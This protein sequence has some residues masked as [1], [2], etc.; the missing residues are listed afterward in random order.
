MMLLRNLDN[1]FRILL[2][3]IWRKSMKRRRK[4]T[5]ITNS[6]YLIVSSRLCV[7]K[8]S[9]SSFSMLMTSSSISSSC[10]GLGTLKDMLDMIR[11]EKGW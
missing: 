9:K 1:R 4:K 11:M 8:S 3:L 10:K 5:R 2:S 6:I 7:M